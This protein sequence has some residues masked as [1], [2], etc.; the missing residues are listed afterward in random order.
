[1]ALQRRNTPNKYKST[2]S[3][4]F[5][6]VRM[7]FVAPKRKRDRFVDLLLEARGLDNELDKVTIENVSRHFGS[8]FL[9]LESMHLKS[10]SA[11]VIG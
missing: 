6:V 1:V 5:S 10:H 8:D 2:K 3:E 7:K 11:T 4:Q 9:K